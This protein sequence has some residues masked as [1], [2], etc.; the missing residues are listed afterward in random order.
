MIN[1]EGLYLGVF[2]QLYHKHNGAEH[3]GHEMCTWGARKPSFGSEALGY[4]SGV[5]ERAIMMP[6]SLG[7]VIKREW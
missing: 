3:L 5:P 1:F 4:G 6:A 2:G 7:M